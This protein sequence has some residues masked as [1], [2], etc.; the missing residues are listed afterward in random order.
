MGDSER[1]KRMDSW[2]PPAFGGLVE[3][4][5]EHRGW[6]GGVGSLRS[7]QEKAAILELKVGHF[8]VSE[9]PAVSAATRQER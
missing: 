9:M 6:A 8:S 1:R 7:C 4:Q 2:E 5:K 3:L